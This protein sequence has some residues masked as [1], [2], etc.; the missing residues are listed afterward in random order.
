MK[1]CWG[2]TN[3]II[4]SRHYSKYELGLDI[5]GYCSIHYHSSMVNSFSVVSGCVEVVE[6]YG[7]CVTKHMLG[8]GS[9]IS[10]NSL[11]PHM[12]IVYKAGKM[13]EEYYPDRGGLVDENDIVRLANGGVASHNNELVDLPYRL[14]MSII[15]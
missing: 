5:N 3:Q 13:I 12:F 8:I 14:M 11:V 1:K 10:I 9:S 7:P 6:F 2:S 15:R 4:S